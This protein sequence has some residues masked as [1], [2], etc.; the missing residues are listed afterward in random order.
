MIDTDSTLFIITIS[1]NQLL[2]GLNINKDSIEQEEL[3]N[4]NFF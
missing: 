4:E 1:I 3:E 2:N